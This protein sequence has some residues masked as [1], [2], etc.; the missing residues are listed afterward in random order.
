[1]FGWVICDPEI[2]ESGALV[3]IGRIILPENWYSLATKR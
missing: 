1:M 3:S 2:A